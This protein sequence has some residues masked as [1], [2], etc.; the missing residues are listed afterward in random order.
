MAFQP[1]PG[2]K[3]IWQD[4]PSWRGMLFFYM[5]NLFFVVIA[6]VVLGFM[7][8]KGVLV[9]TGVVVLLGF[10][11]VAGVMLWGYV[12]R[13]ITRYTITNT[14]VVEES[15]LLIRRTDGCSLQRIQNT[16]V[17]IS[18]PERM[19]GVG[20]VNIETAAEEQGAGLLLW[21]IKNPYAVASHLSARAPSDTLVEGED[22]EAV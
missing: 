8:S 11:F 9:S 13:M 21:G 10:V 20:R 2:E 14:R 22:P 4:N 16:I 12:K 19:L 6:L 5:K 1:S 7:A 15:G 3:I 17:L 18:I